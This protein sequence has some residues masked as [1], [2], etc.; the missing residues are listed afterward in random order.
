MA[1][2]KTTFTYDEKRGALVVDVTAE[3]GQEF[4]N[5]VVV[6]EATGRNPCVVVPKPLGLGA[7][8]VVLEALTAWRVKFWK[9]HKPDC[10]KCRHG[11]EIPGDAHLCCG[12]P[13]A[14]IENLAAGKGRPPVG[15]A[16]PSALALLEE[17]KGKLGIVLNPHGLA[18]GWAYWPWNFDPT[19]LIA[20]KGFEPKPDKAQ[21]A[22]K[23]K[24]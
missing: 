14:S 3:C 1:T 6:L 22:G 21:E 8:L 10:Y 17:A 11:S 15:R 13:D 9:D 20:C 19:W 4:K 12:H 7:L 2:A 18:N 16:N 24:E 23:E 5:V